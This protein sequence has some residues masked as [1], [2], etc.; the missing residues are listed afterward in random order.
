MTATVRF[1]EEMLGHVTFGE[2]DFDRGA[3][4]EHGAEDR[5]FALVTDH[6]PDVAGLVENGDQPIAV[7]F[8]GGACCQSMGNYSAAF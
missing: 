7:G 2:A 6:D 8:G 3:E 4:R 1:T 5:H